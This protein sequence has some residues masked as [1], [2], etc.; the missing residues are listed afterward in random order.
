MLE[1]LKSDSKLIK[2]KII[3]DI[4]KEKRIFCV[5]CKEKKK[6]INRQKSNFNFFETFIKRDF[7]L[8]IYCLWNKGKGQK[9]ME[10]V[11]GE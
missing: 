8:L 1:I 11:D 7:F 5:R 9:N 6:L 3:I 4:N 10:Q 2:E